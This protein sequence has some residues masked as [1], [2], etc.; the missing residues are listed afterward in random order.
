[1]FRKYSD[2]CLDVQFRKIG[3]AEPLG[4]KNTIVAGHLYVIIMKRI[5]INA[6]IYVTILS[7]LQDSSTHG[8]V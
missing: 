3:K 4:E 1:M 8:Q 7:C 6:L 2:N 5:H